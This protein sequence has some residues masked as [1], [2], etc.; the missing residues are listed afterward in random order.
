[1]IHKTLKK[2]GWIFD[3]LLPIHRILREWRP[4]RN[5]MSLQNCIYGVN[6][7]LL[8]DINT[9]NIYRIGSLHLSSLASS[10][11]G[12]STLFLASQLEQYVSAEVRL[13]LLIAA[14]NIMHV[15]YCFIR[16]YVDDCI[17]VLLIHSLC[18]W[19]FGCIFNRSAVLLIVWLHC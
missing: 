10:G 7:Q 3:V 19:L 6:M 9:C 14:L 18:C 17:V 2:I 11:T 16:H 15:V 13:R 4:P 1:M 5:K 8:R 12:A